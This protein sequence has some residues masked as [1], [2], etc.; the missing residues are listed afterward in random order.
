MN[1]LRKQYQLKRFRERNIA[2]KTDSSRTTDFATILLKILHE[3][4]GF[5]ASDARDMVFA[6]VAL[7]ADGAFHVPKTLKA[8]YGKTAKEVYEET[9]AYIMAHTSGF[10]ILAYVEELEVRPHRERFATWCPDWTTNLIPKSMTRE[11]QQY[12]LLLVPS[13][14]ESICQRIFPSIIACYGFIMSPISSVTGTLSPIDDRFWIG[15]HFVTLD[16][17]D[18]VE[19]QILSRWEE[20]LDP[21]INQGQFVDV[22]TERN[23]TRHSLTFKHLRHL[24]ID[25]R[26]GDPNNSC[27]NGRRFAK[28]V[29]PD[30]E[31]GRSDSD[32]E[33]DGKVV[34]TLGALPFLK[35]EFLLVPDSARPGDV[36]CLL[37]ADAKPFLLRPSF[38]NNLF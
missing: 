13:L 15:S 14:T 29:L 35:S 20:F 19:E 31:R 38:Q 6:H 7:C 22:A 30:S 9:A 1:A 27:L 4:R 8:D 24:C 18:W 21:E 11:D 10:G 26:R 17:D 2:R 32:Y 28:L 25:L 23:S 34:R 5:G 37:G 36:L 16:K 33:D 3:R 12:S